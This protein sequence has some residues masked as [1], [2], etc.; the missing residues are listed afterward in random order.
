MHSFCMQRQVIWCAPLAAIV[1]RDINGPSGAVIVY[2]SGA[3]VLV[4][5]YDC[6]DITD[7]VVIVVWVWW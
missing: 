2:L 3:A 1:S 5:N 6:D 7:T 4:G